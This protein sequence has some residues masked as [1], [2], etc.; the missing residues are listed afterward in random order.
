MYKILTLIEN[1]YLPLFFKEVSSTKNKTIYFKFF[2]LNDQ[3]VSILASIKVW[4]ID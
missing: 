4:C 2:K 1:C 3:Q